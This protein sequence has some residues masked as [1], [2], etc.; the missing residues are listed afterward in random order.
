MQVWVP[1]MIACTSYVIRSKKA[2]PKTKTVLQEN[3]LN[4]V[5]FSNETLIKII[6]LTARMGT[7]I[8]T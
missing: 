5:I 1:Y 7:L 3:V 4:S 6:Y 2:N 8:I